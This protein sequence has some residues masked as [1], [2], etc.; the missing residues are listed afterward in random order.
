VLFIHHWESTDVEVNF[1]R[2][3]RVGDPPT[4]GAAPL[5]LQGTWQTTGNWNH[6]DHGEITEQKALT[7]TPSRSLD[8]STIYNDSNVL[9]DHWTDHSGW[10]SSGTTISKTFLDDDV[11]QTVNKEF[12]IAGDFLAVHEWW[13]NEPTMSFQIWKRVHDPLP[14]LSGVWTSA[15]E[16]MDYDTGQTIHRTF[17]NTMDSSTGSFAFETVVSGAGRDEVFG[18]TGTFVVDSDELMFLVTVDSVSK[19]VHGEPEDLSHWS[20]QVLR[21]AYAPTDHQSR[22]M[23]SVYWNEHGWDADRVQHTDGAH[24]RYP[25]GNYQVLYAK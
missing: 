11:L 10:S 25:W 7:L 12:V 24:P 1:D 6:E 9:V 20:G 5:P 13:K 22:V 15:T 8:V 19:V 4:P 16:R 17:T 2:F 14:D 21:W 18:Y 3:T 23:V